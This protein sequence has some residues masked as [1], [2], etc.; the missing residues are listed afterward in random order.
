MNTC[1]TCRHF[2]EARGPERDHRDLMDFI[3]ASRNSH[4][5]GM[6]EG[7]GSSSSAH[8]INGNV[9]KL[10]NISEKR[11]SM[12]MTLAMQR[13]GTLPMVPEYFPHCGKDSKPG[14][15]VLC[16]A[17]NATGQ[18]PDWSARWGAAPSGGGSAWG[19]PRGGW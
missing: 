16:Q 1:Q 18:C 15:Y 12:E 19:G 13:G 17:K 5:D 3:D 9:D 6:A 2:V 4:N 10:T 14:A 11:R 8:T 7:P